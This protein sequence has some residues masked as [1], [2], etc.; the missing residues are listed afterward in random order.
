MNG[1]TSVNKPKTRRIGVF[2][3]IGCFTSPTGKHKA[4]YKIF[5]LMTKNVPRVGSGQFGLLPD[6]LKLLLQLLGYLH[7]FG[8][9]EANRPLLQVV[10]RIHHVNPRLWNM[11][12]LRVRF[13]IKL[14][15]VR[16]PIKILT[17]RIPA[18]TSCE[19]N[20]R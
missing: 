10:D 15:R 3:L 17:T 16:F 5:S 14:L 11:P 1:S 12:L 8:K 20:K 4:L 6:K 9:L 7:P 19:S 13:P 18:S 2:S